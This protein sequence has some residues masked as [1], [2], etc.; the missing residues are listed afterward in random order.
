MRAVTHNA[1]TRSR[2]TCAALE[3]QMDLI[4]KSSPTFASRRILT[5]GGEQRAQCNVRAVQSA[6]SAHSDV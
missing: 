4:V 1:K 6:R 3:E 5:H 2:L